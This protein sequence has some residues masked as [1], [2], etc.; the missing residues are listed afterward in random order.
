MPAAT[1]E[2]PLEEVPFVLP[3]WLPEL[4]VLLLQQ[5]E[6]PP[7]PPGPPPG[8]PGRPGGS[9][10][11]PGQFLHMAVPP[12]LIAAAAELPPPALPLPPLGPPPLE[13]PPLPLPQPSLGSL[14]PVSKPRP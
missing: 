2:V 13:P 10:R 3:P 14:M 12:P 7:P 9:R 11:L 5:A 6:P 8:P 1:L 4:S